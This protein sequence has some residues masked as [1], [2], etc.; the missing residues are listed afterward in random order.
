MPAPQRGDV[1]YA[2]LG[3]PTGHEEA[4]KRPVVVVQ[5]DAL[6]HLSTVVVVPFTKEG[7]P[8]ATAIRVRMGD[9]GLKVDSLALVQ[10]VRVLDRSKLLDKW[11]Q[12]SP[13]A[14]NEVE[15]APAFTLGLP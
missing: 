5:V 10:H 8:S 7:S 15:V 1:W 4:L 11:G 14:M 12:L 9:G 2:D 13:Q 6:N 3:R